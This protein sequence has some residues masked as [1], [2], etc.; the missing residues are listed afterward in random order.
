MERWPGLKFRLPP[1]LLGQYR[2]GDLLAIRW[3]IGTSWPPRIIDP[4]DVTAPKIIGLAT[5]RHDLLHPDNEK[6]DF[7]S[8]EETKTP[9]PPEVSAYMRSLAEKSHA[10]QRGTPGARE[11]ARQAGI[12]SAI[13]RKRKA[14]E[15][16]AK[17]RAEE[18]AGIRMSE[19]Q[20][21]RTPYVGS[22]SN[23]CWN[24]SSLMI[25]PGATW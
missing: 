4:D 12:K 18:A 7:M 19:Q 24:Q 21:R 14:A 17:R 25:C 9:V 3:E 11:R 22:R 15:R 10:A 6:Y 23:Q 20:K 1:E 5:V 8:N 13:A 2:Q 16:R